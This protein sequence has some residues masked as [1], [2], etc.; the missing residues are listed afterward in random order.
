VEKEA[1]F[2]VLAAPPEPIT[3]AGDPEDMAFDR[4]EDLV[5]QN[6]LVV[7]HLGP[8][9]EREHADAA[10]PHRRLAEDDHLTTEDVVRLHQPVELLQNGRRVPFGGGQDLKVHTGL[11]AP[12]AGS[13][14][15]DRQTFATVV[16]QEQTELHAGE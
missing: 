16:D 13:A 5:G 12:L 14:H 9:K 8:G 3:R 11:V 1:A 6:D 10:M 7:G 2:H 15:Q 4:G